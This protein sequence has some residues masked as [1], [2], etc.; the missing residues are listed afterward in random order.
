VAA[1]AI[2]GSENAALLAVQM[3]AIKYPALLAALKTYRENMK[4]KVREKD[5]K[6]RHSLRQVHTGLGKG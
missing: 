2:N 1:V 4:E 3:L 6:I 5:E